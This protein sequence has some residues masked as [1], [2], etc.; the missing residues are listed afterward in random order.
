MYE[1]HI[2]LG[3]NVVGYTWD[4]YTALPDGSAVGIV[5]GLAAVDGS[6]GFGGAAKAPGLKGKR[7]AAFPPELMQQ[8]MSFDCAKGQASVAADRD[9]IIIEIGDVS[10]QQ[11][12]NRSVHG[13]VASASLRLALEQGG[14][15]AEQTIQA[16]RT[17]RLVRLELAMTGSTADTVQ[18]V[19]LLVSA[20]DPQTLQHLVLHSQCWKQAHTWLA[21]AL[22]GRV[23]G[24]LLTLDLQSES[25]QCSNVP[26]LP[27]PTLL[28][29][30]SL[31]LLPTPLPLSTLLPLTNSL[32]HTVS[33]PHSL[34]HAVSTTLPLSATLPLSVTLPLSDT[35]FF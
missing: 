15:L 30:L 10:A 3:G 17:G 20:L 14:E 19:Q 5:T 16:I 23:F 26:P 33:L 7:E 31:P 32:Y 6:T 24:T 18:S 12:L 22:G 27:L 35:L 29:P 13:R 28:T 34:Y 8:G 9:K 11:Q 4:M 1:L 21:E 2:S 25:W